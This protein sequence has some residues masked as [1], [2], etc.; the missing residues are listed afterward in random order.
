[1]AGGREAAALEHQAAETIHG[2]ELVLG[3]G[4]VGEGDGEFG[5]EAMDICVRDGGA[6]G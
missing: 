3:N 5:E 2:A 6:G 4:A 1:M